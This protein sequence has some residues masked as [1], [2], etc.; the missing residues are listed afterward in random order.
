MKLYT[1]VE[2]PVYY[3][4]NAGANAGTEGQLIAPYALKVVASYNF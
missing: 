3:R 2:V 4:T 1:D